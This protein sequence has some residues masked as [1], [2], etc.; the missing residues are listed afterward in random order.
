MRMLRVP[1]HNLPAEFTDAGDND[2]KH[3]ALVEM[4]LHV[5]HHGQIRTHTPH[6]QTAQLARI[7]SSCQKR[8]FSVAV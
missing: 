5:S 4:L 1:F 7:G 6:Y 3:R 2:F 8:P